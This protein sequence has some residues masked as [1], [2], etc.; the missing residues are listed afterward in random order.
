MDQPRRV[1]VIFAL[2]LSALGCDAP[3]DQGQ[4]DLANGDP[5]DLAQPNPP[6]PDLATAPQPDLGPT[7]DYCNATDPRSMSPEV[8]PTPE[9]GEKPY[10]DVLNRA[11]H[12]IR[13]NSYLM[14]YG[15]ILTAL[16]AKAMAGV[17]VQVIFDKSEIS[18]NQKYYDMMMA[19]G[20]QVEWSD[21]QFTYAHA[22][23]FV[24]D[25]N[26]AV[27]STGNYS[28]DYSINL[29]R[30]FAVHL[31]DPADVS[32]LV[33]LFDADWA[34]KTPDLS[35]TR[36]VISPV[37][38]RARILAVI[39]GA[40]STLTIESMQLADSDVRA[41]IQA[42]KTAGVDVQALIADAGWITAN[43]EAATWL[44][45]LG[46]PVKNIPHLHTK[47]LVADGTMA[48][49]GSENLSYTSLNKN[50]EVG[51][52]TTDPIS[53]KPLTDTFAKDWAVGVDF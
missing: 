49:V 41:A 21:P 15:G 10:V 39:N 24:V 27:F 26:E 5:P 2:A 46:I 9:S 18:A 17:K 6:S 19:A 23:Y 44:K 33:T 51:M 35:C 52:I 25:E 8:Y 30:N 45:S 14:G 3:V 4:P 34:R 32:D 40:Q 29:E 11:Q 42:R 13:V 37:N 28:F 38:S 7:M 36:L 31:T 22:K 16:N 20:A 43:A 1:S 50:R 48:Y 53:I 47:V 12:S